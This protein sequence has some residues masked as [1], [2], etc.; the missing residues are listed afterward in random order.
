[1]MELYRREDIKVGYILPMVNDM[2]VL[3]YHVIS[4]DHLIIGPRDF[5]GRI[6][7]K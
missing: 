3:F 7:S 6:P 2:V 1:M 5:V 4:Q